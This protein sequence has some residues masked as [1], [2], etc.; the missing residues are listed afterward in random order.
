MILGVDQFRYEP[1]P[2][3]GMGTPAGIEYGDCPGVAV[4]ADDNVYLFTRSRHGVLVLDRD[5]IMQDCWGGAEFDRPH[6]IRIDAT[7]AVWCTDAGSHVVKKLDTAGRVELVLGRPGM[8]SDTGVLDVDSPTARRVVRGAEPFNTPTQV[9]VSGN[10]DMY[11]SDGYGNARVH[12]FAADGTLIGSWGQ[13]GTE[14]GQ[15]HLPHGIW[16]HRDGRVLVA[17]RENDRVQVFDSDG[18]CVDVWTDVYRPSDLWV[19]SDDH[20]YVVQLAVNAGKLSS[21]RVMAF[22]AP[23]I[24]TIRSLEGQILSSWGSADIFAPD[25]FISAHSLCVDS[26]GDIYVAQNV[27]TNLQGNYRADIPKVRKYAR[28]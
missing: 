23:S 2:D 28:V 17:D 14:L 10:G 21:G 5:G 11:V 12:R 20:V 19:D 24:L 4:D 26:S 18:H 8:P 25:G 27:I 1:V 7:G 16:C 22:D 6:G 13:P 9:S 15:F 3:W